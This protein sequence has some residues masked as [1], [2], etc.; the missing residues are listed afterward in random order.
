MGKNSRQ[1]SYVVEI[2]DENQTNLHVNWRNELRSVGQFNRRGSQDEE[3][4]QMVKVAKLQMLGKLEE[5]AKF[6]TNYIYLEK[7]TDDAVGELSPNI[8]TL[9]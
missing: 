3:Y 6:G 8:Y 2:E 1:D 5:D 9:L 4:E 7:K